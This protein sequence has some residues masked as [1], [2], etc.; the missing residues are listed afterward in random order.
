MSCVSGKSVS[1][2]LDAVRPRTKSFKPRMGDAIS[3]PVGVAI[4]E[5]RSPNLVFFVPNPPPKAAIP[6]L[7][8]SN[9]PSSL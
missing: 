2:L 4:F 7:Y 3:S 5:T 6:T 8:G 9:S 1:N